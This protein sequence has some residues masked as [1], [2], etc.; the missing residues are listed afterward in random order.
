RVVLVVVDAHHHGQV[1]TLGRGGDDDLLGAGLDVLA[2]ILGL[3]EPAGGL[4]DHVDAEL[5]PG[6]LGRVALLQGLDGGAADADG[7]LA[8]LDV[9]VEGAQHRVVLEQVGEGGVVGEVVDGDDLDLAAGGLGRAPEVA[10]DAPETVHAYTDGHG[11]QS[12]HVLAGRAE[13]PGGAAGKLP[14]AVGIAPGGGMA[15][16]TAP[17]RGRRRG[18]AP[19]GGPAERRGP[20]SHRPHGKD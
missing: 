19:G 17:A 1:L 6:Q 8:D 16:L 11:D 14:V 15:D 5:A 10:A 20:V 4:D 7:V 13:A 12:P 18:P 9:A 3:G 2:G